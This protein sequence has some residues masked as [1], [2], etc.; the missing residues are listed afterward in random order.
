[1]RDIEHGCASMAM[2]K[3][4][5]ITVAFGL[6]LETLYYLTT[7]LKEVLEIVY[8]W[9]IGSAR[10]RAISAFSMHHMRSCYM[11]SSR[12]GCTK[13][14]MER[15]GRF[16]SKSPKQWLFPEGRTVPILESVA[17]RSLTEKP[18]PVQILIYD[19]A[20][21]VSAQYFHFYIRKPCSLI[22]IR[23]PQ[24][25]WYVHMITSIKKESAKEDSGLLSWIPSRRLSKHL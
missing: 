19:V 12:N 23:K 2:K 20:D 10:P 17:H 14:T 13:S 7:T 9:C 5:E 8:L 25:F 4:L 16:W 1:M 21:S 24:H 15:T 3:L 11:R 6:T 18:S 22:Q